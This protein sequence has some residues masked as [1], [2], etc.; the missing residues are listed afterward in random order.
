MTSCVRDDKH[1]IQTISGKA[2]TRKHKKNNYCT[3][4]IHPDHFTRAATGAKV[5]QHKSPCMCSGIVG[6]S[7]VPWV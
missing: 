6:L 2:A 4:Y 3:T 7:W 1:T 5:A